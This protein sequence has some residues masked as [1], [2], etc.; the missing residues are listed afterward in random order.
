MRQ[1][2]KYQDKKALVL[3]FGISGINAAHLLVKLGAKVVANDQ[4]TPDDPAVVAD[5]K[6]DGIEVITGENPLSLADEDFDVVVKNP[7]IPYDVPLVQKFMTKKTP[8]ITEAELASEI[9][10]GH[11][12]AVTGS[13]GKTTTTTL[14]EKMVA[15]SNPYQTAY[16]GNIGVS[17]SKT[18]EKMGPD[19]TIV[20]ELS[21]FQLLGA[22]T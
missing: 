4:K 22:P 11:L 8:I 5:L 20:A 18:A 9:F 13:N 1:V 2:T 17:F 10:A 15:K 16:A 3:G 12:I 7:G 21:S 14:I 19:D 6:A